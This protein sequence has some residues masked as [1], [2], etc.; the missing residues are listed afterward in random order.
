MEP[1]S[2]ALAGGLSA[3]GPPG[4]PLDG[5]FLT[6]GPPGKSPQ[7]LLT[8]FISKDAVEEIELA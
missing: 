7:S 2:P 3:P 4:K 8:G 5:E 1:V 6:T